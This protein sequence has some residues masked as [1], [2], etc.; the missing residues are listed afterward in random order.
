MMEVVCHRGCPECRTLS[1]FVTPSKYWVEDQEEKKQIIKEYK[2]AMSKKPCKYFKQGQGMCPFGGACF[3][4]HTLSDGTK[5]DLPLPRPRRRRNPEGRAIE[6]YFL[7]EFL[8]PDDNWSHVEDL[9]WS[10]FL[11]DSEDTSSEI[12]FEL[13]FS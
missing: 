7:W 8:E 5:V 3:Y 12:S 4:N 2:D 11:S 13:I 6:Q 10:S 1:D 9:E